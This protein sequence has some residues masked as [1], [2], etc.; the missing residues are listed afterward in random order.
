MYHWFAFSLVA[1]I[2]AFVLQLLSNPFQPVRDH[3]QQVWWYHGPFYVSIIFL[4][5]VFLVD[6]IKLSHRFVGPV[7]RLRNEMK[8]VA[9][10]Q[11]PKPLKFRDG[12]FWMELAEDY[13][14]MIERL[15]E[16]SRAQ[17]CEDSDEVEEEELVASSR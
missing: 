1:G 14:A 8:R 10:G 16:V 9:D 11:Q 12:D 7:M 13:N 3:I 17:V 4:L 15:T 6:T 2:T 5:P